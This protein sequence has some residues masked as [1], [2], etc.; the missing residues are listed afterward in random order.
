MTLLTR[1]E[2][3]NLDVTSLV[4]LRIS[5]DLVLHEM[6]ENLSQEIAR[7]HQ[8]IGELYERFRSET[9]AQPGSVSYFMIRAAI[10]THQLIIDTN[11]DKLGEIQKALNSPVI[12]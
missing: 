9:P 1:S 3:E 7:S 6:K 11:T 8:R 2:L 12:F 4:D 10:K 5:L